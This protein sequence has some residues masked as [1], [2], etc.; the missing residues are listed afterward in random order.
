MSDWKDAA[1]V[2]QIASSTKLAVRILGN[3]IGVVELAEV[4]GYY[5]RDYRLHNEDG[6]QCFETEEEAEVFGHDANGCPHTGFYVTEPHEDYSE[7]LYQ[8]FNCAEWSVRASAM[9]LAAREDL[10]DGRHG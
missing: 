7:G 6:C 1:D 2:P 3:R 9:E 10:K 4:D 5:L 8:E